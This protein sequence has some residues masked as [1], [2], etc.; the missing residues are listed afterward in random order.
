[1]NQHEALAYLY[2]LERFGMVFG[3]E[4]IHRLLQVLGDPHRGLKVIHVGGTNGKGS[5][6]AMVAS[7]LQEEGYRVGLYTSPHLVSFAERILVNGVPIPWEEVA[8]LTELLCRRVV[9][10]SIPSRFTFFDFTTAIAMYYLSLQKVDFAIVEVGLGGRLDSTN[11]VDPLVTVVT[12]IDRDHCEILGEQ[13]EDIAREKAG[14]VKPGV[15]LISGA[16]QPEVIAVLEEVCRAKK[17]PLLLLGRDFRGV[18]TAPHTLTFHGRAWIYKD[19]TIG[20]AGFYQ[21]A[22]AAIALEVLEVFVEAGFRVKRESLYQGLATV[23][24]PGRLEVVHSMPHVILDGAHNPAAAK[25]LKRCLQEEFDYRRL[26]MV[27]G[28]M[29]DKEVVAILAELAPLADLLIATSPPHPR[30]MSAQALAEIARRY[31][32]EVK[33][34]EDVGEGVAYAQAMADKDDIIVVTGSFFTV[35]AVRDQLIKGNE[36]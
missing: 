36:R 16:T 1:M 17:V 9:E 35:G 23:R 14:I 22:N 26:Y 6:G 7:V 21:I 31:C 10:N 19:I 32:D 25:S 8:W 33:V 34:I 5:V 29:A 3:L 24:W 20:L 28:V 11:V 27:M 18:Q 30:A 2:S 4:N 12:T 13:L 15:P